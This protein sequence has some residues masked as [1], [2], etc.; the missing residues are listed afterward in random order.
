MTDAR[1]DGPERQARP[2]YFDQHSAKI[3]GGARLVG[4]EKGWSAPV[5][6]IH[7]AN[8]FGEDV[9]VSG[10]SDTVLSV[11][12]SGARTFCRWGPSDGKSTQKIA[13][14][15]Q[16][17]GVPNH[18]EANGPVDFAQVFLPETLLDSVAE[19]LRPGVDI[20]PRLRD[21][22]IF[23][24]DRELNAR[25]IAYIRAARSDANVSRVEMDARA[26]LVAERLLSEHHALTP[27]ASAAPR[28][29]ADWQFKRVR[30]FLEAGS[31]EQV[32][33]ADLAD[34]VRLSPFHFARAFKRATGVPPH[35]YQMQLRIERAKTLL[36][37]GKLSV[38]EVAAQVG[39]ANQSY[40]ARLFRDEV[41]ATPARYRRERGK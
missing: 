36:E 23:M 28:G 3:D 34:L 14:T 12:L 22:L 7:A 19:G 40:F 8:G 27:V 21:D 24:T 30:E 17:R 10:C 29:L 1:A 4:I 25:L 16:P 6:F 37:E 18:F 38:G 11:W 2:S 13:Y 15:F 26:I 33:L 32:S 9:W 20:G 31:H 41:G 5:A 39:Y 35:R